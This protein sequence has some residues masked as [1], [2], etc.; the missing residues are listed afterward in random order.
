MVQVAA[1]IAIWVLVFGGA[2]LLF[3]PELF[4]SSP[5]GDPV[6]RSSATLFLPPVKPAELIDY[7]R[8]I[9]SGGLRADEF[10][11]YQALAREYQA[12]FWNGSEVSVEDAL[13]GVSEGRGAHLLSIL[14]ERGLSNDERSV[15]ITLVKRDDPALLE[16]R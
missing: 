10:P 14:A 4:D 3:G 5:S 8:R 12:S 15:F 13:S 11:D 7:E 1:R 6:G 9:A 2:Y 16:D